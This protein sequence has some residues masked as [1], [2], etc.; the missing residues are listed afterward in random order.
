MK[1]KINKHLNTTHFFVLGL[2]H[3]TKSPNHGFQKITA[4][5]I[6][7]MLQEKFLNTHVSAQ[8]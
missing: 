1:N 3:L 4:T 8:Q 5:N 6:T 7:K 2:I